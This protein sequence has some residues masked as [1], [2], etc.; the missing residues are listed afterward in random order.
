[1]PD[2]LRDRLLGDQ[3]C[4][5]GLG[6]RAV[7]PWPAPLAAKFAAVFHGQR[8]GFWRGRHHPVLLIQVFNGPAVGDDKAVKSPFRSQDVAQQCFAGAGTA[9]R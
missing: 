5:H 9:R 1:M 2:G 3:A 8:G 4:M 7:R 6:Q